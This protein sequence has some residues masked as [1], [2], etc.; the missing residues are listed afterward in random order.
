VVTLRGGGAFRARLDRFMRVE[1][2]GGEGAAAGARRP[3]AG[4]HELSLD[5]ERREMKITFFPA[6]DLPAG[7]HVFVSLNREAVH[8][9]EWHASNFPNFRPPALTEFSI[10]SLKGLMP[11]AVAVRYFPLADRSVH[12]VILMRTG[13]ASDGRESLLAE[14]REALAA[15]I[16]LPLARIGLITLGEVEIEADEDVA[17]LRQGEGLRVHIEQEGGGG[18][19]Q[20]EEE[21]EEESEEEEEDE[22]DDAAFVSTQQVC[23]MTAAMRITYEFAH[24]LLSSVCVSVVHAVGSVW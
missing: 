6:A 2:Q 4:V 13:K 18:G 24:A 23:L 10:P 9:G 14:M 8:L 12:D 17:Q 3:V 7:C 20:Q 21:S 5:D 19:A 11:I 15:E 1:S 22:E 16:G